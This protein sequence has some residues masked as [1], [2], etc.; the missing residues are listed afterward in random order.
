MIRMARVRA[1]IDDMLIIRGVNVFPSEIE[2]ALLQIEELGPHYQ[3]F[4]ERE[5]A[6]DTLE[7]KI[8][9]TEAIAFRWGTFDETHIDFVNLSDRVQ[10]VLKDSLGLTA[11]IN[12]MKPNSV[13]RSEGKA[14]RI[15]DN[16]GKSK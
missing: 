11:R 1:R 10:G 5:K 6:L 2:K 3:L 12:L 4:L 8:E 13:T 15:I 7:I 9:V 16:R 14:V